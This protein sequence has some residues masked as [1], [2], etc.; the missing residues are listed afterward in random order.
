MNTQTT[1]WRRVGDVLKVKRVA[2]SFCK[3]SFGS[4]ASTWLQTCRG[5]GRDLQIEGGADTDNGR[6]A[7]VYQWTDEWNDI[8]RQIHRE[9]LQ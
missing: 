9:W 2:I 7:E 6:G 3:D 8:Y 5:M 1:S 4:A